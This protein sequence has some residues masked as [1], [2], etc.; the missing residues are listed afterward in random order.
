MKLITLLL[1]TAILQVSAVGFAQK[2][3]LSRQ[4][5]R[6]EEVFNDI[7]K[8]SGYDFFYNLKLIKQAKYVSV[9]AKDAEITEV[10]NACFKDQPFTYVII[11][12]VVVIK[13]RSDVASA[14]TPMA[15]R[16]IKVIG[17]VLD[18]AGKP[19]IGASI[20]VKGTNLFTV[21]AADGTFKLNGID[22]DAI[23]VISYIGY[24]NANVKADPKNEMKISLSPMSSSL[25][26]VNVVVG[27]GSAVSSR[28][29][30]GFLA[31]VNSKDIQDKPVANVVDALQGRVAGLNI[32][33]SSGEPTSLPSIYLH[34]AGSINSGNGPL[35]VLD[36]VPIDL[37]TVLAL[38][39]NDFASVT[40]LKDAASTSIYGSRAANGVILLTTKQGSA[41]QPAT[42]SVTSQYGV[43]QIASPDYF[44]TLMNRASLSR[45]LVDFG[46][47]TQASLDAVLNT[48]KADTKWGKVIYRNNT[49]TH[50][51]NFQVSGGTG[52]TTYFVSGG[53][54]KQE[55]LAYNSQYNRYSFRSNL[56]SEV[57]KWMKLGINI[58]GSY[59]TRKT[60]PFVGA[61]IDGGL[62]VLVAPWYPAVDDNGNNYEIIPGLFRTHPEYDSRKSYHKSNNTGINPT[63][64]IAIN[65]IKGLIIKSQAGIDAYDLRG[66]YTQLPSYLYAPNNGYISES[67]RRGISKTFTNTAEYKFSVHDKHRFTALMG[68]EYTDGQ[69]R[70]FNAAASG[71]TDD[72]LLLLNNGPLG[73]SVGSDNSEYS[74]Y[75][76]FARGD[77]DWNRKYFLEA[78]L[79]QD[80]SSKFGVKNKSALFYSAGAS[81]KAKEED[82]LN[83]ISWISD[84]TVRFSTGTSGNSSLSVGNYSSLATV[85]STT[86]NQQT[87]FNISNPG[88]PGLTW[89]KQRLTTFGFTASVFNRLFLETTYY[90]RT[91]TDMLLNVPYASTTGFDTQLENT[92]SLQNKGLDIDL[93]FDLINRNNRHRAFITPRLIANIN[94]SKIV[95][96]FQNRNYWISGDTFWAVGQPITYLLPLWAGVNATTGLPTWYNADPDPNKITNKT[97]TNGTTNTFNSDLRQSTGRQV[98]PKSVGSFGISSG[99]EGFNIDIL[100]N[101]VTGKYLYNNDA[102]FIN[103]P[104]VYLNYNQQVNVLDYWKQAG[105]VTQFPKKGEQ[106]T[107]FDSRLLQ[108]ASFIRLKDLTLS[109]SVPKSILDKTHVIQNFSVFFTGRNVLT[110]TKYKGID[111]ELDVRNAI[112]DYPNT[113]QFLCGIKLGF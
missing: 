111:A 94:R 95:S 33:S 56:T 49:G 27:Y 109:Y 91:T 90:I 26:E 35:I 16:L 100:F 68:Q 40:V 70:G 50:Q 57:N 86:Y 78:S 25:Q 39:A 38:N 69:T 37:R 97:T 4:N 85:A 32:L 5:A 11:Q 8:Q 21:T 79:R 59:D 81:W 18:E 17:Q 44:G 31:T 53:Y 20:K 1:T 2:I 46:T 80:K 73:L 110:F 45:F 88:Y 77:Y 12:N 30:V 107:Q 9:S 67:F 47:Q 99:Y 106:F 36:G 112:G 29:V 82:F 74:Y 66:T 62:A 83:N 108:D 61:K 101:Y 23:F 75:S 84:L 87:G 93:S 22:D 7:H 51:N 24:A 92:G 41:N 64:Y 89:E 71:F 58:Y 103:N 55:G 28:D 105:D 3:T 96:L 34:G 6:L 54:F 43:S 19:L 98:A 76:W 52:A 13:P 15:T 113:K 48:Y 63:A 14:L 102:Y 60:F 10:L 65:P 104:S 72:R 42:I